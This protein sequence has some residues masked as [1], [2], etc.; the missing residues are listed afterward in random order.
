MGKLTSSQ[1]IRYTRS[2]K[3]VMDSYFSDEY[4]EELL[5]AI[6]GIIHAA[7]EDN[8][9]KV[10]GCYTHDAIPR[11]VLEED[12]L[13]H[14]IIDFNYLDYLVDFI[15]YCENPDKEH[16]EYL[17]YKYSFEAGYRKNDLAWSYF[18]H[19]NFKK[20]DIPTGSSNRGDI[21]GYSLVALLFIA[22]HEM[23]HISPAAF[24]QD[25]HKRLI[26]GLSHEIGSMFCDTEPKDIVKEYHCDFSSIYTVLHALQIEGLKPDT[27]FDLC[28]KS[29]AS[30]AFFSLMSEIDFESYEGLDIAAS[31]GSRLNAAYVEALAA[32]CHVKSF[33]NVD[34]DRLYDNNVNILVELL[35]RVNDLLEELAEEIAKFNSI[36][37]LNLKI[38]EWNEI[39]ASENKKTWM[40]VEQ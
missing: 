37:D 30:V 8:N 16:F 25:E 19:L 12:S 17:F 31:I 33:D 4:R 2:V 23:V 1:V 39:Q 11:I 13:K 14:V 22:L 28:L 40:A 27:L 20:C 29:L 7:S 9:I 26:E 6:R 24:G 15:R 21:I 10:D 35:S 36:E 32:Q 3:A 34:I 5:G 18:C 38:Q